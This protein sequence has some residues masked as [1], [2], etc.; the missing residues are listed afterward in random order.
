MEGAG[1]SSMGC[2]AAPAPEEQKAHTRNHTP[3]FGG[4]LDMPT[5]LEHA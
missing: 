5:S 1:E 4:I 2:E 3:S